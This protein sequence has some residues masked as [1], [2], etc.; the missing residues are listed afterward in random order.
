MVA[1]TQTSVH[2]SG[3]DNE[4]ASPRIAAK[5][6][7]GE[8][9]VFDTSVRL[10]EPQDW[11]IGPPVYVSSKAKQSTVATGTCKMTVWGPL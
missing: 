10:Y 5:H 7:G 1:M 4:A 11:K 2:M 6:R 9:I 8:K 3:A